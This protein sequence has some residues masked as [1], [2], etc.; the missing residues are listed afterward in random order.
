MRV[1]L[2]RQYKGHS[3]GTVVNLPLTTADRLIKEGGAEPLDRL[4]QITKYNDK[5]I[6]NSSRK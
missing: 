1:K 5:M 6:R 4:K 3:A 2:V